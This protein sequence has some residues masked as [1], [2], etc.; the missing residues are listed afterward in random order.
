MIELWVKP[1]GLRRGHDPIHPTIN[2]ISVT[3]QLAQLADRVIL[4]TKHVA[5][6]VKGGA[7]SP[8]DPRYPMRV[9]FDGSSLTQQP[10]DP[11]DLACLEAMREAV[12]T[13]GGRKG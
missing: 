2:D 12:N 10:H 4:Q 6:I 9:I 5:V 1:E 11:K 7:Q 13:R 3:G 8:E